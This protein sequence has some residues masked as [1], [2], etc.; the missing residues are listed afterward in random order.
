MR[1]LN[2][3]PLPC[4]FLQLE[5]GVSVSWDLGPPEAYG[6]EEEEVAW[7]VGQINNWV[8][9]L[10]DG[11]RLHIHQFEGWRYVIHRDA[12]DPRRSPISTLLHLL[13]E[14]PPGKV[15]VAGGVLYTAVR[16]LI[17]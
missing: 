3:R 2:V 14:T 15:L 7:N 16:V 10:D 17:R 12:F 9:P 5:S 13:F 6:F 4:R 1:Y 8:L 11:S